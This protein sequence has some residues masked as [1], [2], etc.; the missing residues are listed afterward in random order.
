M[1]SL[2]AFK[3]AL[4]RSATEKPVVVRPPKSMMD[5]IPDAF[6]Q[7]IINKGIEEGATVDNMDPSCPFLVLEKFDWHLAAKWMDLKAYWVAK[8]IPND[9]IIP[10]P[11]PETVQDAF[12]R[13]FPRLQILLWKDNVTGFLELFSISSSAFTYKFSI[14]SET[15]TYMVRLN[16]LRCAKVVLEGKAPEL[17]YM[18]ANPNCMNLYGSFPLHEATARCS[19]D[20]IKLLFRHGASA[21]VR[22]LADA[23]IQ[24]LL[25]LHVAVENT[26][27]HK[28]LVDNLSPMQYHEDYIYKL[29][30]LLCLPEMKVFL[31][32]IRLLARKTDNLVDELWNYMKNGKLAQTAV[33][34]LAAQKCMRK[35]KP[36]GFSIITHRI[37]E[38]V[39]SSPCGEGDTV[40]APKQL[41]ERKALLNCKCLL[42][43][44]IS[45]AGEVLYNYIQ[46]HSEVP[47]EEVLARVSS[48]LK[49]FG[50]CPKEGYA[51]TMNLG[52]CGH[53]MSHWGIFQKEKKAAR[54]KTLRVQ[55]PTYARRGVFPLRRS[56]LAEQLPSKAAGDGKPL[57]DGGQHRNYWSNSMSNESWIPNNYIGFL[58]RIHQLTGNQSRRYSAAA[59]KMLRRC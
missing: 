33:L 6:R 52:P 44:I 35:G 9:I 30:H 55:D 26:R 38:D 45:Q 23:G 15:L 1:D 48:I 18:H 5:K 51:D 14:T 43:N 42:F 17:C 40:E 2:S 46:A 57:L 36:N 25:P 39:Y 58:G 4:S 8:S 29:I 41:D 21:N 54:K 27:L 7:D 28:Y 34:F 50:F 37:F 20:M 16:A 56:V 31:D 11:T 59:L 32:P 22:T 53:K 3:E 13:I 49:E 12:D 47:H 10:D 19:V 24:G